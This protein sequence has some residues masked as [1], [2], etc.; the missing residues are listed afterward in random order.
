MGF[1]VEYGEREEGFGCDGVEIMGERG[2]GGR[3]WC[4]G[5]R[6]GKWPRLGKGWRLPLARHRPGDFDLRF[7]IA[8][9]L[10]MGWF[11]SCAVGELKGWREDREIP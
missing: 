8:D 9:V 2:E 3:E 11:V 10:G 5:G 6:E 4:G 1:V 7:F